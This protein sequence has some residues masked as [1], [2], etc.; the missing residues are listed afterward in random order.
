MNYEVQIND[1]N[2]HVELLEQ[3]N[4]TFKI[5]LDNEIREIDAVEIAEGVYSVIMNGRSFNVELISGESQKEYRINANHIHYDAEVVDA[6]TKYMRS[7]KQGDMINDDD[8]LVSP[9]PGK[10][11]DIAVSVGDEIH[12]GQTLVVVSAMKMES[13]FKAAKDGVVKEIKVEKGQ[14]VESNQLLVVTE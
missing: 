1:R 7:R 2:A 8:R 5:K 9:V 13:E 3:N 12:K 11:I 14:N 6:E 4:S 10:V